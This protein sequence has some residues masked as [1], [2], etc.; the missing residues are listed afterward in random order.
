VRRRK[1]QARIVELESAAEQAKSNLA[2]LQK[3]KSRL[4]VE[5]KDVNIQLDEVCCFSHYID[6]WP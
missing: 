3:D 1:L 6:W 4:T 2:K 5:I